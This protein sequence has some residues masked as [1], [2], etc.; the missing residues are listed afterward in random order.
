MKK[1]LLYLYRFCF[2]AISRIFVFAYIRPKFNVVD[3]KNSDP[4]PKPPFIMV[5]NHATFFDPWIV[6]H[7]SKYPI[8]I[9]NNEDAFHS[10]WVIR[11]YLKNIVTFPKKKGGAAGT[12]WTSARFSV[13]MS[14]GSAAMQ[15]RR[16]DSSPG[17]RQI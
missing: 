7:Y 12:T 1:K 9:M 17:Y 11:W 3:D 13:F 15:L 6:G 8:S 14:A 5:S 10:P 4:I 2:W 16:P